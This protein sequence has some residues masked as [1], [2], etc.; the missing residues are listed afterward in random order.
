VQNVTI[1]IYGLGKKVVFKGRLLSGRLY[2]F[3]AYTMSSFSKP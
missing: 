1:I 2:R 3:K